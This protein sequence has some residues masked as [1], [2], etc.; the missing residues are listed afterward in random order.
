MSDQPY[1]ETSTWQHTTLTT[2]IMLLEGFEPA[3]PISERPQT[4]AL[5]R[6]VTGIGY[7]EKSNQNQMAGE[8]GT[9]GE[10]CLHGFDGET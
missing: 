4:H 9:H 10:R 6:A 1:T 8:C 2:D 5:D 7:L 3:T